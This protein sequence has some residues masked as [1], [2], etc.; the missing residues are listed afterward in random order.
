MVRRRI[1]KE[2]LIARPEPSTPAS[3]FEIAALLASAEI[4]RHL[5]DILPPA[6]GKPGGLPVALFRAL[7]LA[8]WHDLSVVR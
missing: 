4:D 1:A 5:A 3:V 7:A 8:T 6:K 2:G